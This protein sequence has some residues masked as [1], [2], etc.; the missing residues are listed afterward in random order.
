MQAYDGAV[1]R[2]DRFES[3]GCQCA[4]TL[5]LPQR[6]SEEKGAVP[7]ILMMHGWGGIQ[8]MLVKEYIRCFN[9]AGLAVMTFDY[10]G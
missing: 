4:A 2:K 9:E 1:F 5:H 10:P 6:T 3:Q 7:A 8:L